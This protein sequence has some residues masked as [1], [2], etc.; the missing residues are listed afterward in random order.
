VD[1]D[2][3]MTEGEAGADYEAEKPGVAAQD[4]KN[5]GDVDNSNNAEDEEDDIANDGD[6]EGDSETWTGKK[7]TAPELDEAA[8]DT[9]T[10]IHEESSS[11]SPTRAKRR[12]V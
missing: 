2:K 4:D 1:D 11:S 9:T 7:R 12:K 5:E 10:T 8:V 6:D 3:A